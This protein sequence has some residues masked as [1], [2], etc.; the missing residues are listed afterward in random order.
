MDCYT[1]VL[2]DIWGNNALNILIKSDPKDELI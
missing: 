2:S 1:P